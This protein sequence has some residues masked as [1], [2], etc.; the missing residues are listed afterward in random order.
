MYQDPASECRLPPMPIPNDP[1]GRSWSELVVADNALADGLRS[2]IV[3]FIAFDSALGARIAGTGFI[4]AGAP[5]YALVMTAKH[6]LSEG[7]WQF[8]RRSQG[9]A[10]STPRE[11]LPLAAIT[12]SID[13]VRLKVIWMDA[14]HANMLNV[15]HVECADSLDLA[16]CIVSPQ[17]E[18]AQPFSPV[19]IPINVAL[20]RVGAAVNMVTLSNMDVE[21][22][23]LEDSS[24]SPA[25]K[26]HR[27]I[28]IRTGS[29]TGLYPAGL[30]HYDWPCFTTSIPALAGMSGGFV[31]LPM[32]GTTI[33]ACGIV[34]ADASSESAQ[35]DNHSCGESIIACTWPSLGLKIPES[36][37]STAE[38]KTHTLHEMMRTGAVP[39][40]LGGL[41]RISISSNDSG[42]IRVW[43]TD[44]Q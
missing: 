17:T 26:I 14:A 31:Y 23:D 33:A 12:P 40:A 20:P 38:T 30:R 27:R 37:P 2:C 8:Q 19:S 13:P 44:E 15:L 11:F 18:H 10:Y 35:T 16:L 22:A 1:L 29:V 28:N 5:D 36:I 25:I 7:V 3:A 43:R 32:D 21:E 24:F 34:C 6:V 42:D 39:Q 41:E 4:V 9:F